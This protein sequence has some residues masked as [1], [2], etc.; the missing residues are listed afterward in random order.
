MTRWKA[1][2]GSPPQEAGSV[3]G[4]IRSV[5]STTEPGQPCSSNSGVASGWA[6]RTCR[7]CSCV[8]DGGTELGVGVEGRLVCSPVV[9]RGPVGG[10]LT[11]VGS[12]YAA[13]PAGAGQVAGPPGPGQ[14]LAEVVDLCLRD[15]DPVRPDTG[16]GGGS[17]YRA[18]AL[19]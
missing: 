10:Q 14:A 17:G 19:C 12:W 3:S 15:D 7:K 18:E 6:E 16:A 2:A 13:F 5:N 9:L 11:Q 4:P 8:P 1:S